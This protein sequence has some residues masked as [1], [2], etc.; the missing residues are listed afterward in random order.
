FFTFCESGRIEYFDQFNLGDFTKAADGPAL[1]HAA[2]NFRRQVHF[3][4]VLDV[5]V[6]VPEV[7]K[8]SLTMNYGIFFEATDTLVADGTSV[9]VWTDYAAGRSKEIPERV[10]RTIE[11]LEGRESLT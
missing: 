9:V 11:L 7:R 10:R 4:A 6:S 3:P 5:G 2:L 1:V 8:S